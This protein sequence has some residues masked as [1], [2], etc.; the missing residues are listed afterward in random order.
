M[1][2]EL[3][4]S[5]VGDFVSCARRA[6][7]R[8]RSDAPR[9]R[10]VAMWIGSATH[11]YLAEQEPPPWPDEIELTSEYSSEEEARAEALRLAEIG[12]RSMKAAGFSPLMAEERLE[13][14]L[15]RGHESVLS[16]TGH[17]DLEVEDVGT[18][19]QGLL[20][21]KTGALAPSA[22][23]QLGTYAW[24]SQ[25]EGRP[26][27]DF[28]G[29]M[30]LPRGTAAREVEIETRKAEPVV[31]AVEATLEGIASMAERDAG[32]GDFSQFPAN[33]TC[34]WCARCDAPCELRPTRRD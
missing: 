19:K 18:G 23:L 10:S 15:L 33:P 24:L 16:I 20:E 28:L 3:R 5:E 21:V 32:I 17:Y 31:E 2:L 29:V 6:M 27:Y 13:G 7:W 26:N 9:G 11:A 22:W 8:R 25:Y 12:K 4:A 34:V 30:L 14:L 1:T